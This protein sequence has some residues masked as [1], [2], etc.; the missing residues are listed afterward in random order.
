[1]STARRIS[2]NV[3]AL[4]FAELFSKSL[5]FVIMVYAARALDKES[6]GVFSFALAFSF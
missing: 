4:S 6:F 1:M 3:L 2:K 5:Q